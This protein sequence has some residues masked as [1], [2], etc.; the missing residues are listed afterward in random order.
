M[1][2]Q[3]REKTN[4]ATLSLVIVV[5]VTSISFLWLSFR[6]VY[7]STSKVVEGTNLQAFAAKR[8]SRKEAL[9]AKRGTIY[10]INGNVIA[11]NVSSYTLIA[12]L[13]PIRTT[14]SKN[15]QH[16]TNKEE[17]AKLLAPV[18]EM[19]EQAILK[20]LNKKN[21][22]QT[23]FGNKG[24]GLTELKKDEIIALGI[25]GIDF[26]ETQKRYYPYGDFLSYT[27]GYAKERPHPEDPKKII[28][29]GEM[30]L[31]KYFDREL[32]GTDGYNLYQKDRKGYK[33]PGTKEVTVAAKDGNDI[34]LTIDVN[35][36]LF[37]EQALN[38]AARDSYWNW[39][40]VVIASAKDGKVMAMASD[41]S[42]NPN[43][44]DM[45]SYLDLNTAVAF[46][47]GSTM[48]IF[49]YMAAME[50][51]KYKGDDKYLSGVYKTADGTEIGDWKRA[52]WG[53]ISFDQGFSL[54]SNTAII[55]L[56][57]KGISAKDL[58][59]YYT[60]LGFGTKTG[61]NLPG[62]ASGR[63]TFKY[64][65]EILNAGFGQGLTTTAIQNVKA[66]T[67]IT[68]K[69][70]TLNPYIISKVINPNQHKTLF[71]GKK[72][73]GETVASPSTVAKIT[74][75]MRSVIEGSP[76]TS[77][78]YPY[79]MEGYKLAAKT[80]T[81]QVALE[82]GRGYS[83]HVIKALAGF[84]PYDDPEV[85]IYIATRNPRDKKTGS[86]VTPM[87]T[88]VGDLVKNVSSY[89]NIYDG[90]KE[91][92]KRL[93]AYR[94]PSLINKDIKEIT[95]HYN[96]LGIKTIAL[97]TGSKIIAQFPEI[98]SKISSNDRLILL[99][100]SSQNEVMP[101]LLGLSHKEAKTVC[102]FLAKSCTFE[103]NGF[104]T[105]QSIPAGAKLLP[106]HQLQ[107]TLSQRETN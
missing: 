14:N 78:G 46:E 7:L 11:Q 29:V 48:K 88:I 58:R 106:E 16:V 74:D 71:E 97:G 38:K 33:I 30:G 84:F 65:T 63:M 52:G 15:P 39:T 10:D 35:V 28:L 22:Y 12:Y 95:S 98:G 19:D 2:K 8:I 93:I 82:N 68:N 89:L 60:K 104:V 80:G 1:K 13:D 3:K 101:Q 9:I 18:L 79:F 64:E 92:V 69:G 107:F 34:Y 81:A 25:K 50:L 42:F 36:Q 61:I 37:L 5:I 91:E 27:I 21:V 4:S 44:R 57:K 43:K 55:N 49:S 23:E 103:G 77:T 99:T 86:E 75:L 45:T 94:L 53:H 70:K 20:N 24:K 51:G 72:V 67:A 59:E 41:P 6:I 83:S 96:N 85:I 66:L 26:I 31:E 105:A 76:S 47:P 100:S 87:K 17:A 102:K 40:S 32:S 56:I 54:S 90:N 62:E 73:E